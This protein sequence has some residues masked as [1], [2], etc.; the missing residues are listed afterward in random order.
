MNIDDLCWIDEEADFPPS[1]SSHR[2]SQNVEAIKAIYS[3][4]FAPGLD[5]LLETRWFST[6]GFMSL[7]SDRSVLSQFENYVAAIPTSTNIANQEA[8]LLWALLCMCRRRPPGGSI[9]DFVN[10]PVDNLDGDEIA[11]KRLDIVEALITAGRLTTNPLKSKPESSNDPTSA[12]GQQLKAREDEFW[13]SIGQFVSA[14]PV[15][16][17][18]LEASRAI[19]AIEEEHVSKCRRLL[20]NF[21]NRDVL[22]SMML[23]RHIGETTIE[24]EAGY[25]TTRNWMTAQGFLESQAQGQATNIVMKRFCSM[26]QRPWSV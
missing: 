25:D 17:T 23:L 26:A 5:R 2:E 1:D 21:E 14:L 22:Y 20:D 12:L 13:F 24:A 15:S 4:S 18:T 10:G 16:T 9:A 8:R 11:S 6:D 3:T 7:V 19:N